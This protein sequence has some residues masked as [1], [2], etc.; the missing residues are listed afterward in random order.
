M[1]LAQFF[2]KGVFCT[3]MLA[4]SLLGK[5]AIGDSGDHHSKIVTSQVDAQ[6]LAKHPTWRR[7]LFLPKVPQAYEKSE[8]TQSNFFLVHGDVVNPQAELQAIIQ[9]LSVNDLTVICQFP[10]RAA[11]VS[12]QIGISF[13]DE[14]CHDFSV[15]QSQ[16][17]LDE[18]A[19]VFASEHSEN[20]ASAFAHVFIRA[21][22]KGAWHDTSINYT[23]STNPSDSKALAL[24][25]ALTGRSPMVLQIMPYTKKTEQYLSDGRDVWVYPLDLTSDEVR[26]IMRH[27]YETRALNRPY[28]FTHKNCATEILRLID[29]V[30]T[31][32][33]LA[34]SSGKITTPSEIARLLTEHGMIASREFISSEVTKA[35]ANFKKDITQSYLNQKD[36]ALSAP[37]H[38]IGVGVAKVQADTAYTLSIKGAYH[39]LLDRP[40]GVR[41][42]HDL[43]L[44]TADIAWQHQQGPSLESFRLLSTRSYHP[45]DDRPSH[46]IHLG[47]IKAVDASNTDNTRHLVLDAR[48][49][50][51]KAWVVGV[52]GLQTLMCH[53]FLIKGV[54]LGNINQGYRVGIGA[55]AGCA[56]VGNRYRM[57]GEMELP[58]WLHP[59]KSASRSVY[60]QPTVKVAAQYDINQNEAVRLTGKLSKNNAHTDNDVTLQYLKYF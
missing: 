10:A 19:L 37:M 3:S 34:D 13:D 18:L 53:A 38:R 55:N 46:G 25:K 14:Q 4:I 35:Q 2:V 12:H 58:I 43:S 36:P 39:D 31:D 59:D 54:Q 30:R 21:S 44:L 51:G 9:A 16:M 42:F 33:N 20:L 24:T 60:V 49:E 28:F 45:D 57:T 22:D 41:Q 7:L 40:Q 56:Y 17:G 15:W 8:I 11:F 52:D 26:Q 6:T 47:L 50:K 29:V 48:Q 27:I 32:Q 23:V 1:K 5:A